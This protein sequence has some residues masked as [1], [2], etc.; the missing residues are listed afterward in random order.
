MEFKTKTTLT[1]TGDI[2]REAKAQLQGNW[3]TIIL[4]CLIPAVL[5]LLLGSGSFIEVIINPS[6]NETGNISPGTNSVISFLNQFLYIGIVYT[7]IDYIRKRKAIT[8]F[9]DVFQVFFSKVFFI[10]FI[11]LYY[12]KYLYFSLVIVIPYSRYCK[13]L[14][15]FSIV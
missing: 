8:P 10:R 15:L 14:C 1:S 7:L 11:D 3:R 9:K 4:L 5:G 13:K 12:K 2:K 6:G